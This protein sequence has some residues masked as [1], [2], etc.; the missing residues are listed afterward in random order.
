[1][2]QDPLR[3]ATLHPEGVGHDRRPRR[4]SRSMPP[5]ARRGP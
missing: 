3:A 5:L 4:S 2:D 1:V